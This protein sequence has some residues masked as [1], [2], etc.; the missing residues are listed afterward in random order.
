PRLVTRDLPSR[1]EPAA[2]E[3]RIFQAWES[4]GAFAG[5]PH[6][7]R[8]PFVIA[9]PPPNVTGE[10]HMGHALN[11]SIEDVLIR[12]RKMQGHETLWICGPDHA[13]IATQNVV[14]KELGKQGQTRH[15]LG[16]E[17]FVERV[18]EWR[19]QYGAAIIQQYK[20]LGCALDYDNERFTMDE[21][22]AQAVMEVFVAL[23]TKGYIF[24]GNRIV[25]WC[26]S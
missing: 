20:K 23:Y 15:D 2:V 10:L 12:L 6:S 16:R 7:D 19:E 8:P 24:R 1:F 17:A 3:P 26:P 14:E 21:A 11:G 18:W 9:V 4:A 22:Y 25:N 5:D 13:G